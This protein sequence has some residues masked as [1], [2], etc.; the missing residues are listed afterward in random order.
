MR[1]F[2][3]SDSRSYL[4]TGLV[5]LMT[6]A[7]LFAA[8]S[9]YDFALPSIDGKPMPL[10]NFK[11]KV[12]L[13][14]NVASRCGYTPQYTAL[15]TIYEKY[16][17]RGLVV[18]GF[19]ANNFGAQEPG[20]NEEIKTFCSTKYSVKFPLYAKIS[21]K[22]ADQTPLYQFL[23]SKDSNP[24]VAGDIQWNFTKFLADRNGK[25]V[26]RFEPDVTPDSLEV[27]A[28]IEKLLK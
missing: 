7:S 13:L 15:E 24:A 22:G 17:D 3:V 26:Q 2:E 1:A 16:K 8:S 12:L 20:T 19:P 21:V 25:I 11:G 4:L 5:T 18:L 6:A 27:I 10:A 14:V 28:A 9:L 23:T